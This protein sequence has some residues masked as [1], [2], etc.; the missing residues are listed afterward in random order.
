M[1][2][3]LMSH[4]LFFCFYKCVPRF[5]NFNRSDWTKRCSAEMFETAVVDLFLIEWKLAKNPDAYWFHLL[6]SLTVGHSSK[7]GAAAPVKLGDATQVCATAAA[8]VT[9]PKFRAMSY[10]KVQNSNFADFFL[11]G[12]GDRF[13]SGCVR[14]VQNK[15]V[16]MPLRAEKQSYEC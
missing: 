9:T 11:K 10:S 3:K 13:L 2:N 4:V 6:L 12:S 16:V 7:D 15:W 5:I 1:Y 8:A 14:F